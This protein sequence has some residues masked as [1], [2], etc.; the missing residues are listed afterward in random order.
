MRLGQ[1][2]KHAHAKRK[3]VGAFLQVYQPKSKLNDKWQRGDVPSLERE[4]AWVG[5]ATHVRGNKHVSN[6]LSERWSH[7]HKR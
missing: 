2:S 7:L 6:R 5:V 3:N 4:H 1:V